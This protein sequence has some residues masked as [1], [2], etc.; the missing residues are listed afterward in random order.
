MKTYHE[1][2]QWVADNEPTLR[3][4]FWPAEMAIA[5]MHEVPFKTVH[6]DVAHELDLRAKAA[7]EQRK[8]QSRASNEQ[9]R[10]ANLARKQGVEE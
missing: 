8:A 6:D 10:L 3:Y 2:I 7:K 4:H 5:E 1:M 9:R